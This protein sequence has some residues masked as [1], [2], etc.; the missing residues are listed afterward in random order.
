M[1]SKSVYTDTVATQIREGYTAIDADNFEGRKTFIADIAAGLDT[2][3]KSVTA[4]IVR[5]GY[6][7]KAPTKASDPRAVGVKKSD[8]VDKNLTFVEMSSSDAASLEKANKGALVELAN[9]LAYLT[10]Q[11]EATR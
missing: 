5:A 11:A 10:K 4:H 7:V 8:L 1:A 2:S 9:E 6:F 3:I